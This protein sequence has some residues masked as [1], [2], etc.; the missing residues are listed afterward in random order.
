MV[1]KNDA[2][3]YFLHAFKLIT[4]LNWAKFNLSREMK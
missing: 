2:R 4:I 1:E 3:L